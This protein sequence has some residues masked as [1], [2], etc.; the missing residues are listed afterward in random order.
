MQLQLHASRCRSLRV[1]TSTAMSLYS[2]PAVLMVPLL[3]LLLSPGACVYC[4]VELL[5]H[6]PQEAHCERGQ[7]PEAEAYKHRQPGGETA[8]KQQQQGSCRSRSSSS[9]SRINAAAPRMHRAQEGHLLDAFFKVMCVVCQLRSSQVQTH[10]RGPLGMDT[11]TDALPH[12]LPTLYPAGAN[13]P[14]GVLPAGAAWPRA[15]SSSGV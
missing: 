7:G 12:L 1:T 2:Q 14:A 13:G 10:Q 5:L 6:Q 8:R 11:C 3:L 9:M 15:S 4:C